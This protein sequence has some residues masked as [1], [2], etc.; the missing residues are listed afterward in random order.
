MLISCNINYELV[1]FVNN[2]KAKTFSL[3]QNPI[4]DY[5]KYPNKNY[6]L[7]TIS[8]LTSLFPFRTEVTLLDLTSIKFNVL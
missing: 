5:E 4:Q 6:K 3:A 1:D 7:L 2:P 8:I